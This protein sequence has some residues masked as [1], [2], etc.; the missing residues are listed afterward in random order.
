MQYKE[1]TNTLPYK[2]A[3]RQIR[4]DSEKADERLEYYAGKQKLQ[5]V[6]DDCMRRQ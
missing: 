1:Q 2:R 4:H 3:K 6:G 5:T